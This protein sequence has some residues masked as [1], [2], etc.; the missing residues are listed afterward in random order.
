MG[1]GAAEF[2]PR[3]VSE[4]M[5]PEAPQATNYT[6]LPHDVLADTSRLS[7]MIAPNQ[8]NV[9]DLPPEFQEVFANLLKETGSN[10]PPQENSLPEQLSKPAP[11]KPTNKIVKP[12]GFLRRMLRFFGI[13][14]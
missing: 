5:T 1:E 9:S 8:P 12:P 4:P 14:R 11:N 7:E 6:P 13:G 3:S 2:V 10:N